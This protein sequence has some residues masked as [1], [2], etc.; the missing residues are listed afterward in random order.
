MSVNADAAEFP[1]DED[2]VADHQVADKLEVDAVLVELR[3]YFAAMQSSIFIVLKAQVKSL[4]VSNQCSSMAKILCASTTL[5]CLSTEPT[6]P[7]SPSVIRPA[8]HFLRRPSAGYDL[9]LG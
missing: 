1:I 2:I 4:R 7:A 9:L 5:P 6:R 8:S 3:P